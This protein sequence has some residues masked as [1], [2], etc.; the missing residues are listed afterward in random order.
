M[1]QALHHMADMLG[2]LGHFSKPLFGSRASISTLWIAC[3]WQYVAREISRLEQPNSVTQS[4]DPE[5]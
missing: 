5:L 4:G 1:N 3:L 2:L